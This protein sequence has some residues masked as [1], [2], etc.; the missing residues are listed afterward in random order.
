MPISTP[1][2]RKLRNLDSYGLSP[3]K[4][5]AP[6]KDLEY[7]TKPESVPNDQVPTSVKLLEIITNEGVKGVMR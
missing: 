3:P 7:K 6:K 5:Q 4:Y 2:K 1:E